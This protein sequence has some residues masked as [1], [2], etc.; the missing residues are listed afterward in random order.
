MAE[1][2][3]ASAAASVAWIGVIGALLGAGFGAV[4]TLLREWFL[5]HRTAKKDRIYLAILVS[6]QLDRFVMGCA[7]V[8]DDDGLW[9]GQPDKDGN[10]VAQTT[11]PI[12]EPLSLKVEWKSL[13]VKLMYR[14]LDFPFAIEQVEARLEKI[15][16]NS[17]P[18][19]YVDWFDERQF[20]Y[21]K[22]GDA[23]ATLAD[24][25][26]ATV[27][28][29]GRPADEWR[30]RQHVLKRLEEINSRRRRPSDQHFLTAPIFRHAGLQGGNP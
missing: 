13:P 27:N 12:F 2:I 20:A 11:P 4:L 22:L 9:H 28:L 7:E 6:T 21:A 26:R 1:P 3:A 5:E 16:D 30:S 8:A 15:G 19:E 18:P 29:P 14:V 17:D 23:A 10:H 24:E 25:L